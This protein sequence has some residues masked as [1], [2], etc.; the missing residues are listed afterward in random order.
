[1]F[2]GVSPFVVGY[3]AFEV[4]F[5]IVAECQAASRRLSDVWPRW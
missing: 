2:L 5:V 1:M 4:A 3:N